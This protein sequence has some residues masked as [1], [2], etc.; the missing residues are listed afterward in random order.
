MKS[1][2]G[3]VFLTSF[4]QMLWNVLVAIEYPRPRAGVMPR[5]LI[6]SSRMTIGPAQ[7]R[8]VL[9][10]AT[11]VATS[12][13]AS[14]LREE[15]MVRRALLLGLDLGEG[16]HA[17]VFDGLRRDDPERLFELRAVAHG[18]ID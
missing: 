8:G 5:S 3:L 13:A 11:A 10:N 6:I 7:T 2:D 18:P 15:A 1:N 4:R 9:C 14:C 17:V 16:R 12:V